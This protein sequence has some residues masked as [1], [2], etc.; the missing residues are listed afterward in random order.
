[1]TTTNYIHLLGNPEENFYALGLKDKE[2]FDH[3]VQVISRLCMRSATLSSS[4]KKVMELSKN[5]HPKGSIDLG[6]QL[7]AYAEGLGK[8]INDVYFSLLLPEVVSAFNR[9]A[10]NLMGLIPGCSS[11]FYYDNNN[12]GTV[13]TRILD[14]ALAGTFEKFERTVLYDFS[15]RYKAFTYSTVG[16]PFPSLSCM[17]EKG[18]TLALHYKHSDYFDL[19]G[20]SIFSIAYQIISYCSNVHEVKKY[21]KAH[22]SISYWGI[23]TSDKKGNVASFDVCGNEIYQEK[24]DLKE[25]PYLYFNNRPLLVEQKHDRMQPFGNLEQCKMRYESTK[26]QM[27]RIT[28]D[29]KKPDEQLLK[30]LTSP[31]IKPKVAAK[32]YKMSAITPSTIQALSFHSGIN[33]SYFA[34]GASPKMYPD[35]LLK[36]ENIFDPKKLTTS[37]VS[38]EIND[39][40]KKYRTAFEHLARAQAQFDQDELAS[41]YHNI[42]MAIEF[43]GEHPM[44]KIATF[45]FVIWQYLFCS[46]TRDF[47]YLHEEMKAL[48]GQLPPY[49]DAHRKLF[50]MRLKKILGHQFQPET[51]E[52]EGLNHYFAKEY[53]MRGTAIKLLRKLIIPRLE[54]F[55]IIYLF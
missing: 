22:P 55:D 3:M 33:R 21:L 28:F 14:Y 15:D 41:A 40:Q 47:I 45:Y 8:P 39:E 20:D 36:F 43:F 11:L 12:G 50:E 35:E 2:N 44:S 18:L 17:N 31:E 29:K 42:Q 9:W 26:A 25:H 24:F 53:K 23:Y 46:K 38:M 16:M 19:S 30:V 37:T 10:P 52:F 48:E 54:I 5:F 13:H 49:L 51:T 27:S 32:N 4:F 7:N 1:M 34:T 6:K